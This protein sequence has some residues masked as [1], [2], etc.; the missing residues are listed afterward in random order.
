MPGGQSPNAGQESS[1]AAQAILAGL[2][3]ELPWDLNFSTLETITGGG[4]QASDLA[5]A[6]QR[7]VNEKY[8]FN[9]ASLN[10]AVGLK[11]PTSTFDGST[12]SIGNS[13]DH[14]AL[15]EQAAQEG[16]VLLKNDNSTLPIKS[17]AKT[18][19]VV[20]LKVAW[21]LQGVM[22][23]GSVDFPKD[24]RI[25]DLGSSRVNLDPSKAI[26]PFAGIQAAAP[27]GST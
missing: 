15:A 1:N 4:I 26:G 6:A 18:V 12:Y 22:A 20:G 21:A 23:S 7:V 19:A 14:I 25:G 3:M 8:R 9:V 2:D 5:Q 16:M 24:A 27:S 10:G 13:A 11:K 17:T